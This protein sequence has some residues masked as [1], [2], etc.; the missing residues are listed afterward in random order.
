MST[1]SYL[2]HAITV[3]YSVPK[4]NT[5]CFRIE[6]VSQRDV[7][8]RQRLRLASNSVI[9]SKID[10]LYT[11]V[12]PPGSCHQHR[13]HVILVSALSLS[14]TCPSRPRNDCSD[15][16]PG[17]ESCEDSVKIRASC[18]HKGHNEHKKGSPMLGAT[19][20]LSVPAQTRGAHQPNRHL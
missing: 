10:C 16:S 12:L 6:T 1:V 5:S 8:T 18:K 17:K 19:A 7:K 9:P 4:L 14:G 2:I 13:Q 11:N 20:Q 3:P 15:S